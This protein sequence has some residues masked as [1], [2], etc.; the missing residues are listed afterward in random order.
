MPAKA[1]KWESAVLEGLFYSIVNFAL[2]TPVWGLIIRGGFPP[3]NLWG[4]WIGVVIIF[5]LGPVAWPFVFVKIIRSERLMKHLQMPYPTAWDAFFDRRQPCFLLV[6]LKDGT[7]IGGYF[8]PGSYAGAFP[9]DG[10]LYIAAVY[11][12]DDAGNFAQ[13]VPY[14]RGVLL[15]KE[16]YAYIEVFDVP[17]TTEANHERQQ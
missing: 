15:R 16:D 3:S 17:N 14:T 6:H 7:I 5:I 8:G 10:D 9:Q 4:F 2:C 11:Q 12:F 13:P 1:L